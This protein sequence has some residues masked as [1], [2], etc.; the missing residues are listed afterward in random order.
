MYLRP[1]MRVNLKIVIVCVTLSS[2]DN[3][4]ELSYILSFTE[5]GFSDIITHYPWSLQLSEQKLF[6]NSELSFTWN[7][8]ILA[9]VFDIPKVRR[10]VNEISAKHRGP[11]HWL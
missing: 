8:F 11:M 2:P 10:L 5:D 4:R 1:G 6:K 7:K 3:R 9:S